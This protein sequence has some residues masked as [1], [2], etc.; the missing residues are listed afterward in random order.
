VA[1]GAGA[2]WAADADGDRVVQLVPRTGAVA[3]STRL[4]G[5]PAGVATDGDRAWTLTRRAGV[6]LLEVPRD[7]RAA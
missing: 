5:G 2:V 1:I 4:P 3:A 6:F 7:P